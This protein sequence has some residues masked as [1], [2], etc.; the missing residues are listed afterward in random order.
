MDT[1]TVLVLG[2]VGLGAVYLMTRRTPAATSVINPPPNGAYPYPTNQQQ[3]SIGGLPLNMGGI[4]GSNNNP[5]AAQQAA[6]VISAIG[7]LAT[8]IGSVVRGLGD[9]G[10]FGSDDNGSSFSDII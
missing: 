7:G 10:V 8:G 5:T 4:L 3:G 6:G 1:S 9:A 2:L